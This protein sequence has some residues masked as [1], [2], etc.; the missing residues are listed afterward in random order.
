M[1]TPLT[2]FLASVFWKRA[3]HRGRLEFDAPLRHVYNAVLGEKPKFGTGDPER[4]TFQIRLDMVDGLTGVERELLK[5]MVEHNQQHV[6]VLLRAI[7]DTISLAT[8]PTAPPAAG[9]NQPWPTAPGGL[10]GWGTMA[11]RPG[12]PANAVAS[13]RGGSRSAGS[14]GHSTPR[15]ATTGPM[16]AADDMRSK[17]NPDYLAGYLAAQ[18]GMGYYGDL[19]GPL[20]PAVH[21]FERVAPSLVQ[22]RG[23]GY[24]GYMGGIADQQWWGNWSAEQAILGPMSPAA[25]AWAAAPFGPVGQNNGGHIGDV[26]DQQWRGGWSAAKSAAGPM[27]PAAQGLSAAPPDFV[28]QRSMER[29]GSMMDQQLPGVWSSADAVPGRG[30]P[31][32]PTLTASLSDST[33][34]Q[35]SEQPGDTTG[36]QPPVVESPVSATP[37]ARQSTQAT[38]E[39]CTVS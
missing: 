24:P 22:Q 23:T 26:T 31:Y 2:T 21:A 12:T 36:Q 7:L 19:T 9:N 14:T 34:Q 32:V 5:P 27:L 30:S 8:P 11:R 15:E 18:R 20:S 3:A 33:K 17:F 28:A 4:W 39:N 16:S 35:S 37:G 10:R 6:F 38:D 1:I 29:M 13:Y 25:Q